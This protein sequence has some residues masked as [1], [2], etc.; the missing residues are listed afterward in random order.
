[1]TGF[2]IEQTESTGV[3]I[4]D[5]TLAIATKKASLDQQSIPY[6]VRSVLFV[7]PTGRSL[8]N[9]IFV[10]FPALICSPDSGDRNQLLINESKMFG[11]RLATLALSA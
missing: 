1:M 10:V 9:V 2:A 11:G 3:A 8:D 6:C 4:L 7:Q 5:G